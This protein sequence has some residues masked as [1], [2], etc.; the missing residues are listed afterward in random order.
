MLVNEKQFNDKMN[1]GMVPD[2][3]NDNEIPKK[4]VLGNRNVDM[5]IVPYGVKEIGD[6]AFAHC[7]M[8][9]EIWL[10]DTV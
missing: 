7:L 6:W 1:K 3:V 10:P 2:I 4:A 5:I 9:K 8:L